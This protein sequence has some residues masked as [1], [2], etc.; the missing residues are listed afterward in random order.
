[1]SDMVHFFIGFI[2]SWP[3]RRF[4]DKKLPVIPGEREWLRKFYRRYLNFF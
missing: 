1:M 3:I 2:V 4:L